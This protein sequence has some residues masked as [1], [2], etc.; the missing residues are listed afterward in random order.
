MSD[1]KPVT[2][3]KKRVAS[4]THADSQLI[5]I[6]HYQNCNDKEIIPVS[7]S[8][9][10]TIHHAVTVRQ[11]QQTEGPRLDS[12][13]AGVPLNLEQSC[14]GIHRQCYKKFVN[15]SRLQI[16]TE[17]EVMSSTASRWSTRTGQSGQTGTI[18]PPNRCIFCKKERKYVAGKVEYLSKCETEAAERTIKDIAAGKND[19]ELLREIGAEDLRAK[20]ARYHE[21][22]RRD[23]VRRD[24]RKHHKSSNHNEDHE[25]C[26]P[27]GLLT[28]I[29][30]AYSE[31][32]HLVCQYVDKEIL[33][34]GRVVRMSMLHDI[35]Q[36]F[37]QQQY[38][39]FY[40]PDNTVQKLKLKLTSKYTSQLQFW[41]PQSSCKS[42]LVFSSNLDVGE[43]VEAAFEASTSESKILQRAASI[44][45]RDIKE[46]FGKTSSLPWPPSADFLQ[47]N[48]ICLPQSVTDFLA[49]VISGK[50]LC[51]SSDKA[52]LLAK[53]FSEDLCSAVTQGRWTMPKHVLLGMSL[54]HLTGSAI[55]I[56]MINRYGHCQSYAKILELDTALAYQVQQTDSLLPSNIVTD[57]NKMVHLCWDNFDINEET[58]SGS[59]TTHT[60]HGIVIQ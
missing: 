3:S 40:N 8:Q 14:H 30:K 22:C 60:T 16:P 20:E 6:V 7:E 51:Q 1:E 21:S 50:S 2:L 18:F 5:C 49:Q 11:A 48:S 24:D 27:V 56:T 33:L 28:D 10:A 42:E 26:N 43:A 19:F 13:C 46:G 17:V 25:S 4:G 9:F 45:R 29:K 12:I 55:A 31:G 23:Y 58:P 37:M 52:Q 57:G 54:R 44:L 36:K 32:F 35:T 53:S 41:L 39:E 59:G 15:V 47:S 34:D 38:P